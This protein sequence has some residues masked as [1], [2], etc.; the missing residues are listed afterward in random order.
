MFSVSDNPKFNTRMVAENTFFLV[1]ENN[2]GFRKFIGFS[3]I[4][5][6]PLKK[7]ALELGIREYLFLTLAV[8]ENT[9]SENR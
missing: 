1:S 5:L 8:S 9:Q 2:K 4:P 6:M 7:I 3:R